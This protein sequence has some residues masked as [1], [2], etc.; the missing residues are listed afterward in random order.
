[1][2]RS[3]SRAD[4]VCMVE[5]GDRLHRMAGYWLAEASARHGQA[6]IIYTDSDSIGADGQRCLPYFKPAFDPDLLLSHDY[7]SGLAVY[8]STVID[9]FGGLGVLAP[10]ATGFDWALRAVE[11]TPTDR[12]V[13]VADVLFSHRAGHGMS[14]GDRHARECVAGHLRRTGM[15][16]TVSAVPESPGFCRVSFAWPDPR[17][18]V[19]IVIPTRDQAALLGACIESIERVTSYRN[20][21]LTLIDNGSIEPAAIALLGRLATRP[22]VRVIHD[23]RPFNFSALI[24]RAAAE[25]ASPLLCV[26]NNDIVVRSPG[27]LGDLAAQALRDQIGCA[28]ARLWYP[29]GSLQHAGIVTGIN[30]SAGHVFAGI[31]AGD[32]GLFGRAAVLRTVTAVTAAC[33][34]VQRDRFDR[35]GGFDESFPVAFNDVDFCLRLQACGYRNVWVPTAELEHHESRSRGYERDAGR[36]ARLRCDIARLRARWGASLSA[37]PYYSPNLSLQTT[38]ARLRLDAD[39]ARSAP[40]IRRSAEGLDRRADLQPGS[41]F[42]RSVR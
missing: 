33:L 19:D 14:G 30:E 24:N 32:A 1:R 26:L 5:P 34:V 31:R 39:V 17:P 6:E 12:I 3:S 29:D 4:L 28:G 8:R 40:L 36:L 18:E 2:A 11:A 9:R 41:R 15:A 22:H 10:Q 42:M 20:F 7:L 13:H 27:W 35:I 23:A 16:G 25:S 38:D 37:D 21:R